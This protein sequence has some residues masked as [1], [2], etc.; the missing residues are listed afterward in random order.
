MTR[1]VNKCVLIGNVRTDI[2][3]K[4]MSGGGN[5]ATFKVATTERWKDKNTGQQREETEWHDIVAFNQVAD[6]CHQYL[7]KGCVVYVEGKLKTKSWTPE[8]GVK[9]YQTSIAVNEFQN[10]SPRQD[11]QPE[12]SPADHQRRHDNYQ[13]RGGSFGP[14]SQQSRQYD[15]RGFDSD[16]PF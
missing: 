9:R 8:D 2:E 12:A 5:V 4:Q 1:G 10:L 11:N 15:D 3:F 13:K 6:L 7:Q 16:I 14:K